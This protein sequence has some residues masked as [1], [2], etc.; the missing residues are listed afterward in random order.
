LHFSSA[1]IV[2]VVVLVDVLVATLDE[3]VAATLDVVVWASA[4]P[5]ATRRAPTTSQ[6]H[7]AVGISLSRMRVSM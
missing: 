2:L 1:G 4:P 3:V 7:G 6:V 5:G